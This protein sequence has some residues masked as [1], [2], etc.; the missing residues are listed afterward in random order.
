MPE[1]SSCDNESEGTD[2]TIVTSFR[3]VFTVRSCARV[4]A[5]IKHMWTSSI[6]LKNLILAM[7]FIN[8][9]IKCEYLCKDSSFESFTS[10]YTNR[11]SIRP[12]HCKT[13]LHSQTN[14]IHC[15]FRDFS[16]I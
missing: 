12:S 4:V 16:S 15:H 11:N 1:P 13:P 6:I 2:D 5:T 9:I 3:N 8:F 7:R 10:S 14:L